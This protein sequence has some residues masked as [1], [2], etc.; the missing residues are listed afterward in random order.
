M[1]SRSHAK[2]T[3][4]ASRRAGLG[5]IVL[6]ALVPVGTAGGA[7][8][9]DPGCST[10]GT[11]VHCDLWAK[12][13]SFTPPGGG[14]AI[15]VM[16]YSTSAGGQPIIPGPAIV[17]D[18]NDTVEIVLH[19]DLT[20]PTG[21]LFQEQAISVDRDGLGVGTAT[22]T[23]T[24][25]ASSAGTYLYEASPFVTSGGHGS[26][27][28]T[29]MGMYGAL[30]VHPTGQAGQAY[31]A[32]SAFDAEH[33]VV[34]GE[35]DKDLNT[36]PDPSTFDMRNYSPDYFLING[37]ASPDTDALAAN[38]GD[39]VL[40][41]WVN[42]GVKAHTASVLGANQRLVGEDG[43]AL[44]N[45]R[46]LV[47]ETLGAGQTEDVVVALDSSASGKY[48]VYDSGL[49]LNNNSAGGMGGALTFLDVANTSTDDT[50]GPATTG[51]AVTG[52]NLSAT[53]SDSSPNGGSDVDA[54][55]YFVDTVGADGSGR[56]VDAFTA[57]V[58]VQVAADLTAGPN[59]I[60]AGP[61]TIYVHGKDSK[62]NWGPV[63]SAFFTPPDTFGPLTKSLTVTPNPT[64]GGRAIAIN[65]TGDET[66]TGG[67]TVT[68]GR[69]SIDGSAYT[70]VYLSNTPLPLTTTPDPVA[71]V[72]TVI[73]AN[74]V[75]GLN[76]A[77]GTHTVSVESR[78]ALGNWGPP[79]TATLYVDTTGPTGSNVSVTPTNGST[80]VNAST[81]AV[82][83]KGTFTD[84]NPN[85]FPVHSTIVAGEGFLPGTAPANGA[86]FQLVP[87]DG[88]FGGNPETLQADIPLINVAGLGDGHYQ[89]AIHGRDSSGNWGPL[90]N[91]DLVIDR[92]APTVTA[93]AMAT[94]ETVTP[95]GNPPRTNN[96]ATTFSGATNNRTFTLTAT[97]TDAATSF[98]RG[99]WWTGTDPGVGKGTPM[100]FVDAGT[101]RATVDFVALGWSPGN[102]T[103]NVRARDAAGNWS[104]IRSLTISVVLPN[105]IFRDGF[106]SG[107]ASAWSSISNAGRVS[108]IPAANMNGTGAVGMAV[109]VGGSTAGGNGAGYVTDNL[110]LAEQTYR[111]RFNFNPNNSIPGGGNTGITI[112]R[113]YS[114]DNGNGQRFTVSYRRNTSGAREVRLQ[115]NLAGGGNPTASSDWVAIPNS[116]TTRIDIFWRSGA[117]TGNG[118]RGTATLLVDPPG[119]A[120]GFKN[121][122]DINTGTQNRIGSVRL[123][124][125]GLG[126]ATSSRSGSLYLDSFLSTRRT[127]LP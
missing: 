19:N 35:V 42:A 31:D 16:G 99:E 65:A 114:N 55:E 32:S 23:Y 27:Y 20:V 30:V 25:T 39:R 22:K 86:G 37:K 111:A 56:P 60:T 40:L 96:T 61:H 38:A 12:P 45:P 123:G 6:A 106:E 48:P 97:G 63:S 78:D 76:L 10:T 77:E 127:P 41:R 14:A 33:L 2:L 94:P 121:L 119:P 7:V 50:F 79:A 115:V 104:A 113:G 21:M 90:S 84:P 67:S 87:T 69:V 88:T 74:V 1:T 126:G 105:I 108:F 72:D 46:N 110:P 13:G 101:V 51:V 43:N 66:T 92:V 49:W 82:R 125:Q 102:R 75:S 109:N 124:V 93:L 91:A 98:A 18:Q 120:S 71:A 52:P 80:G 103:L 62:G 107:N 73:P 11:T 58:T 117:A 8:T 24:F 47:A 64:N 68:H 116:G 59:P 15:P 57:A 26:Q 122:G 112:F 95:L 100:A 70:D 29:A 89:I 9:L 53:V 118:T 85:L 17:A 4:R 36:R 5:L 28:Q 81:P 3:S 83:V 44:P 54:A 34:V